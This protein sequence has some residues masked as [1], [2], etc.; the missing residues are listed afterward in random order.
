VEAL[1]AGADVSMA[2]QFAVAFYSACFVADDVIVYTWKSLAEPSFTVKAD[3]ANQQA[4]GQRLLYMRKET[5]PECLEERRR[6]EVVERHSQFT[7]C[8]IILFV[9][10]K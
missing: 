5:K 2:G 4:M 6:E 7:G 10:K 8:P 1:Q 9:E 3:T